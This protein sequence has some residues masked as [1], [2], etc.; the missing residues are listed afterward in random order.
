MINFGKSS[1]TESVYVK[2]AKALVDL[3]A[4]GKVEGI[5][6]SEKFYE[7]DKKYPNLGWAKAGREIHNRWAKKRGVSEI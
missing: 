2:E 1:P 4:S 3:A 5:V 7:M 6:L